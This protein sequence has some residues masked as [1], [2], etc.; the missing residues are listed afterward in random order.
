MDYRLQ[1]LYTVLTKCV[2]CAKGRISDVHMVEMKVEYNMWYEKVGIKKGKTCA[3]TQYPKRD[4]LWPLH[5][6]H[7]G[8]CES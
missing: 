7:G 5:L 4:F 2:I 1:H 8:V 3:V 6:K